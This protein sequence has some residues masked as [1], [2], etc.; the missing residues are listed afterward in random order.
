MP[1]ALAQTLAQ[2]PAQT[3]AQTPAQTA[4]QTAAHQACAAKK[5]AVFTNKI[6]ADAEFERRPIWAIPSSFRI[7]R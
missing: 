6:V 2:T 5:K 1:A 7:P 3:A 4:A